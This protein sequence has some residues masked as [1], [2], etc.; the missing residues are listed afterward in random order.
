[1]RTPPKIEHSAPDGKTGRL[2]KAYIALLEVT[3]KTVTAA[4]NLKEIGVT[5]LVVKLI[6]MD[7]G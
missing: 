1:M 2:L 6:G 4:K 7:N 5:D 3:N